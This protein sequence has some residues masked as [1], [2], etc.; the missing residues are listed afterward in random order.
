MYRPETIITLRTGAYCLREPIASSAYGHV[1][2]ADGPPGMG[3]VALKLV[4][5]AQMKQA[6]AHQQVRWLEYADAE[7]TLL[8]SLQAWEQRHIVRLLDSG[9]HN[10]LP[11]LALELLQRDLASEVRRVHPSIPDVIDWIGQVNQALAKVHQ[12]SWRYLDLK[13]GNLLLDDA[14]KVKL[15]DFGTIRP[16]ADLGPHEFVG[17]PGWQ[18]PEQC[19]ANA[20]G[21]YC[22][23]ARSDYFAL[24]AVFFYLVMQGTPLRFCRDCGEALRT[25]AALPRLEAS[26]I[27]AAEAACFVDRVDQE[28]PGAGRAAHSLLTSLLAPQRQGRPRHALDISRALAAIKPIAMMRRAA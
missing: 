16:L 1:W 24:G 17:S 4:N 21:G 10:G 7:A 26:V 23:D 12:R 28:M 5:A 6:A 25:S 8:S 9:S 11:V 22:T 27:T 14:G 15:S 13:P 2:R 19:Y 3:E 20:H 18:A